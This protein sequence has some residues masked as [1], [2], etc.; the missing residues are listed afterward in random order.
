MPCFAALALLG[1]TLGTVVL[2]WTSAT[3]A[4]LAFVAL[5][6]LAVTDASEYPTFHGLWVEGHGVGMLAVAALVLL[7]WAIVRS[8]DDLRQLVCACSVSV[9]TFAGVVPV[10]DE[11]F[12]SITLVA[13]CC[14]VAWAVVAGAVPPRWYAVPRVPL[15]G[16]LLVLAPVPAVLAAEA[17]TNLVS[18]GSHFSAGWLVRLHPVHPVANPV[19]LPLGVAVVGLAAALTVPRT[20]RFGYAI[21]GV[22][23]LTGFLTAALFPL[24]LVLF[25]T[26]L[27]PLGVLISFPSAVLT[28]VSLAELTAFAAYVMAR[29]SGGARTVATYALPGALGCV[30]WVGGHVLGTPYE[31]RSLAVLVVLGLLALAVPRL[32][33]ELAV[34]ITVL[35]A[36]VTGVPVA[37]DPSVSLAVHLT[38]AGALVTVTSLVHR[39]HRALAW[40]GGLLLASATWVR[41]YDL[42][43]QAPEAYTLPTAVALL[44]V[45]LDRMR[46][47]PELSS[48]TALLAGLSLAVVPTL[49]W[50]L[51]YPLSAR[52]VFSGLV[53]L[54]LLVRGS[55]L[56]W[57]APVLVG[58]V[59]GAALVLRELAPYAEQTPQLVIIGDAGIVLVASGIT[60]EARL[61]DLRRAAGYLGRLR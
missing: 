47:S 52:A 2:P 38:V 8:H 31:W 37:A 42:G 17:L 4:G 24:P 13:A 56:R 28:L 34:A 59:G 48:I 58:W 11:G 46:R 53:C 36:A 44:L 45:G 23:A 30:L 9:L 41:L 39:D 55:A 7:P 27:G 15:V 20:S 43:V 33:L 19:L 49:L 57:T 51:V 21:L 10:F 16:S 22:T 26:V 32:E 60:W 54:A 35:A 12:T 25:V 50:A 40:L 5:T 14:S 61:R 3:G 18:V 1:R 29:R 6:G